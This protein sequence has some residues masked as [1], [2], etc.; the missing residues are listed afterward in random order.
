MPML[1]LIFGAIVGLSL[2][3]TGGGGAIFAVPLLGLWI[4][5][6]PAAGGGNLARRRWH[7]FRWSGS[8]DVGKLAQ[9]E[10]ATGLMFAVA[11]MIGAPI[12]FVA[13]GSRSPSPAADV[14]RA[15][16]ARGSRSHVAQGRLD[17]LVSQT[18]T[19][20]D[21]DGPTCRRDAEGEPSTELRPVQCSWESSAC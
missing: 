16:D 9:V 3:L 20:E 7:D 6:R 15:A 13:V 2:G 4:V 12:R 5:D 10:V 11:G 14:V 18:C 21:A 17:K 8:S 1:S 19:T